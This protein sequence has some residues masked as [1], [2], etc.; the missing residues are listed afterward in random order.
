MEINKTIMLDDQFERYYRTIRLM[1]CLFPPQLR[2]KNEVEW[3]NVDLRSKSVREY[4]KDIPTYTRDS[5]D[6]GNY[7]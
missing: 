1:M 6:K 4:K 7:E 2:F 5:G 3:E